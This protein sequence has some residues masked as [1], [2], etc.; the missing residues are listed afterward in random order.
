MHAFVCNDAEKVI[1][2][3]RMGGSVFREGR[4]FL[5]A[6]NRERLYAS[7]SFWNTLNWLEVYCRADSEDALVKLGLILPRLAYLCVGIGVPRRWLDP[8]MI[9]D[10]VFALK[11]WY[12]S[13]LVTALVAHADWAEDCGMTDYYRRQEPR[14][15]TNRQ[16][17]PGWEIVVKFPPVLRWILGAAKIEKAVIDT[18]PVTVELDGRR[19]EGTWQLER[20]QTTRPRWPWP[21]RV[22]ISSY[23]DMPHPPQFAGK[24][25][26]SWDCDDDG[27]YGMGTNEATVGGAV[28]EYVKAV[29]KNRER[30]GA[31]RGTT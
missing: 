8:W 1:H 7:W 29:L 27:I 3:V 6:G 10:R 4:F 23:I 30:Y 15:Y 17:W 5:Y 24:G 25:E 18:K 19:Y 20:W 26:N 21:Y 11:V 31:A 2:G 28:G 14:R 13:S 12:I 16:L 22:R 9:H